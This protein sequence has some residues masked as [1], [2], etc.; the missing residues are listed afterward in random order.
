MVLISTPIHFVVL[1]ITCVEF[2]DVKTA[3]VCHH[4]SGVF[5]QQVFSLAA[6]TLPVKDSHGIVNPLILLYKCESTWKYPLKTVSLKML[7]KYAIHIHNSISSI[8]LIFNGLKYDNGDSG[9]EYEDK[10][11]NAQNAEDSNMFIY[12]CWRKYH[13]FCH[14]CCWW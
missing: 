14:S 12:Y 6:E 3:D 13:T 9:D 8:P 5:V 7:G 1:Q 11:L 4:M 2:S 10:K